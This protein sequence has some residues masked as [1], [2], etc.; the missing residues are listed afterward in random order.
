MKKKL[1]LFVFLLLLMSLFY[2]KISIEHMV[3]IV[4]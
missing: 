1:S 3:N 4:A 2:F